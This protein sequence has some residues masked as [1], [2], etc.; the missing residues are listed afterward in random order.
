MATETEIVPIPISKLVTHVNPHADE[1]FAF[2]ELRTFGKKHFPGVES[3]PI[4][5]WSNG[6]VNLQIPEDEHLKQG[7]L[8]VGIGGGKFDE[9]P[10][11]NT[12]RKE[13]ECA[14][15]LVAKYL[16]IDDDP[17]LE[18]LLDFVWRNDLKG[19]GSMFDIASIC[20]K[21]YSFL[22]PEKVILWTT[23]GFQAIYREQAQFVQ[24][25][26]E[27]YRKAQVFTVQDGGRSMKIV[28]IES[29]DEVVAK[30]A[31]AARGGNAT[32]V[33]QRRSTGNVQIF[34]N[35]NRHH[36]PVN[37]KRVAR[38]IR[39]KEQKKK[40]TRLTLN[41]EILEQEG[42]VLGAEEWYLFKGQG[43][44]NGSASH[45]DVLPT[46]LPLEEITRIVCGCV[47]M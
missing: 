33:I 1:V 42:T 22:P 20:R 40:G 44:F 15:T 32:V 45:P 24:Q 8:L 2:W 28:V 6:D 7:T 29:N 19:D 12:G 26:V 5:F 46:N 3:A 21:M 38:F 37:L 13:R 16:E 39:L 9:H 14:A 11:I 36:L 43:L 35:R 27:E 30:Y 41:Q 17:A 23:L 34:L 25:A 47:F 18:Y 31:R 10:T 4:E